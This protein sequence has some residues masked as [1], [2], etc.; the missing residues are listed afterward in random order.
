MPLEHSLLHIAALSGNEEILSIVMNDLGMKTAPSD[1]ILNL[2]PLHFAVFGG[3]PK[4]I[5]QVQ[6]RINQIFCKMLK[7]R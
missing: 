1:S 6:V 2:S 7:I 5:E 3:N 4:I